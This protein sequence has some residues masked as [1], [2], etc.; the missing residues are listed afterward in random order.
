[1]QAT[2][3]ELT[4]DSAQGTARGNA[5]VTVVGRELA[6][7]KGVIVWLACWAVALVTLP[8]PIVHFIAPPLLLVLGPV[9]GFLVF[10]V[11]DGASDLA[12]GTY[13]CPSCGKSWAL[14][15]A[16]ASWP[17]SIACQ[18]CETRLTIRPAASD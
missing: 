6:L 12:G 4:V 14:V 17:L 8:I 13:E 5:E 1:M 11:C 3:I 18:G 2:S 16:A 7:K 9:L 10:R 15:P